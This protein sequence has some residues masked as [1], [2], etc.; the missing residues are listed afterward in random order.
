MYHTT[1]VAA[2]KVTLPYSTAK[3]RVKQWNEACNNGEDVF[4]GSSEKTDAKSKLTE[5]DTVFIFEKIHEQ[6]T[7]N[8][9]DVTDLLC[10]HFKDLTI[11]S[12]AVNDHMRKRCHLT[13][14][15]TVRQLVARDNDITILQRYEAVSAWRALGINF[16]SVCVFI[17]E[18]GF[19]RNVHR[20]H[21]WSDVGKACK[22]TVETKGPNLSILGAITAHG[23]IILSR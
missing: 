8:C 17:D 19:Y 14:K 10:Q 12:R 23:V 15:Q 16:F 5:E 1:S 9:N 20:S 13:Y 3:R 6:P 7:I 22:I 21:G 11:T 18:A 4:P 2:K